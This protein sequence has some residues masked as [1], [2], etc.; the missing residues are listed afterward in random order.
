[1]SV[2]IVLSAAASTLLRVEYRPD[3]LLDRHAYENTRA[4]VTTALGML[5]E[6]ADAGRAENA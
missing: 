6:Q 2:G 1:M 4:S 5:R 3:Q